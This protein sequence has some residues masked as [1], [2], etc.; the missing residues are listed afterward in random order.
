MREVYLDQKSKKK[1]FNA[2]YFTKRKPFEFESAQS[3]LKLS[4]GNLLQ[5][6]VSES[7]MISRN[8][9][10]SSTIH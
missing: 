6:Q 5:N 8:K 3:G 2:H 10:K 7:D 4:V 1:I 9:S